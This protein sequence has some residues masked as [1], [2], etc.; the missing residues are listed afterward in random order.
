MDASAATAAQSV[1]KLVL[2]SS[3]ETDTLG[4]AV[5]DSQH[6]KDALLHYMHEDIH[7]QPRWRAPIQ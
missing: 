2:Y 1:T 3:H 5:K 6:P 7:M 4:L